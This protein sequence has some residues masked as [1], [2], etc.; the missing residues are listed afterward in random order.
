MA[1]II[2]SKKR[3]E[4]KVRDEF[5]SSKI[6]GFRFYKDGHVTYNQEIAEKYHYKKWC[7]V[8]KKFGYREELENAR[9]IFHG[10]I[11][12][13]AEIDEALKSNP[14]WS[15]NGPIPAIDSEVDLDVNG[16]GKG[17]V[18][19]FFTEA[20]W[21]GVLCEL[22]DPPEWW[23][24]QTAKHEDKVCHVFGLELKI[25]PL[26]AFMR[27][28]LLLEDLSV[29]ICEF[30]NGQWVE[31]YLENDL[32][33]TNFDIVSDDSIDYDEY[34]LKLRHNNKLFKAIGIDFDYMSE[35]EV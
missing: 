29:P 20:G 9:K 30:K 13:F 21:L 23:I 15:S 4:I 34:N 25:K 16:L 5:N 8:N 22:L 1:E 24:K 12:K 35:V 17:V 27:K 33:E 10:R 19:G 2:E 11:Q 6:H 7:R 32:R 18:K 28:D 3:T 31:S 14:K 26:K